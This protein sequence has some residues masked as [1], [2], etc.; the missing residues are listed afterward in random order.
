VTSECKN[1]RSWASRDVSRSRQ[2]ITLIAMSFFDRFDIAMRFDL[3]P[4]ASSLGISF[5]VLGLLDHGLRQITCQ[6][7]R[8]GTITE[9]K[10]D[11]KIALAGGEEEEVER[12]SIRR[13]INVLGENRWP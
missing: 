11:T 4:E 3:D 7:F 6:D 5:C 1:T 9:D 13:S 2:F 8:D 12:E 10:S